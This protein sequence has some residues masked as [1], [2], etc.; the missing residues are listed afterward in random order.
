VA[1]GKSALGSANPITADPTLS[2]ASEKSPA[3]S[4]SDAANKA[5]QRQLFDGNIEKFILVSIKPL[6]LDKVPH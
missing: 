4:P 6:N 2:D 3:V 5:D 1:I